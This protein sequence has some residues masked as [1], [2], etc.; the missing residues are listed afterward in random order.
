MSERDP[1][2]LIEDIIDSAKKILNYTTNLSFDDLATTAKRS[3]RSSEILNYWRS[4][5]S[6][7]GEL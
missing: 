6:F 3:M 1:S 5:K 4:S 2:L 7:A